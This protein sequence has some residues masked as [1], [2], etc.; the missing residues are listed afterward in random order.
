MS[1]AAG[2]PYRDRLFSLPPFLHG[3]IDAAP[4]L[5]EVRAGF[6][7]TEHFLRAHLFEARGLP[8]PEERA[9]FVALATAGDY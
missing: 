7:L 1:G 5:E 8:L 3:E 2:A 6:A 4:P 9:R